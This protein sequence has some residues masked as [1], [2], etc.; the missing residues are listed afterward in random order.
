M[1]H[2][3]EKQ[4]SVTIENEPGQIARISELLSDSDI[5]INAVSIAENLQGGYFRFSA[6]TSKKQSCSRGFCI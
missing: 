5:H 6:P 3:I 4:L 1:R 2:T